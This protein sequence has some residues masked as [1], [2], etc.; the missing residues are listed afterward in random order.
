MCSNPNEPW[1]W[2]TPAPKATPKVTHCEIPL[3][4][5]VKDAST[6][7]HALYD[8]LHNVQNG[9]IQRNGS[10]LVIAWG[11]RKEGAGADCW[12]GSRFL[13]PMVKNF[14]NYLLVVGWC[15]ALRICSK[16]WIVS[17][18]IGAFMVRKLLFNL[19][20]NSRIYLVL[21]LRMWKRQYPKHVTM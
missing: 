17:F 1:T 11:W 3:T 12:M 10:R 5:D 19:T 2:K 4:L 6:E 7:G 20:R 14:W 15:A 18:N 8:S 21:I 9:Q 13:W 16:D